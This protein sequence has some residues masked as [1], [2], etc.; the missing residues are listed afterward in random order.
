MANFVSVIEQNSGR[1]STSG[2]NLSWTGNGGPSQK[3]N[4]NPTS[5]HVALSIK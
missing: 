2:F 1:G 5:N 3:V 4:T